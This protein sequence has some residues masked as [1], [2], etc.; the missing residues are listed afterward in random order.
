MPQ[1]EAADVVGRGVFQPYR[2]CLAVHFDTVP[3][4][5]KGGGADRNRCG[6]ARLR[7]ACSAHQNC[8]LFVHPQEF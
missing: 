2:A 1:P 4:A 3:T 6:R 8:R 5:G 7:T